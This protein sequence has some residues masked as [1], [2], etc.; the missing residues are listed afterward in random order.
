MSQTSKDPIS[1]GAEDVEWEKSGTK[2]CL[3]SEGIIQKG[4]GREV[5]ASIRSHPISC[6]WWGWGW[7]LG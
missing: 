4:G 1:G 7:G 6:W 5:E 2:G 3:C